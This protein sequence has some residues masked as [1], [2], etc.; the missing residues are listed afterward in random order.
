MFSLVIIPVIS[1]SRNI[2]KYPHSIYFIIVDPEL[3]KLMFLFKF[4]QFDWSK[5]KIE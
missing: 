5:I 4:D 1:W 2:L 3:A